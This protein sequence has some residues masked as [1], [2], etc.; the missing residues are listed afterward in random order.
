M[1]TK[2]LFI[3]A[4]FA[5]L[6]SACSQIFPPALY[7]PKAMSE[8]TADLKKISENYI[9]EEVRVTEKEQLTS[10]FGYAQVFMRDKE[11]KQFEQM[12]YYGLGIPHNDPKPRTGYGTNRKEEPHAVNVEDIIKQND[13]IEKY[14]EAAKLQINEEFE[15]EYKFESVTNLEFKADKEGALQIRFCMNVTEKGNSTR[16]EGGQM[17]TDY[18]ELQFNVDKDGNVTYEDD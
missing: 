10:E 9:I 7:S 16:R 13:N 4:A 1:K 6:L 5:V 15:G 18:Y 8:L 17:V 3:V 11:G 2:N 12:L 14:V